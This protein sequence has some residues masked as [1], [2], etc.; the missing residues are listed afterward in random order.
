MK[1]HVSHGENASQLTTLF[2]VP[3]TITLIGCWGNKNIFWKHGKTPKKQITIG[4]KIIKWTK[5]LSISQAITR[6][7]FSRWGGFS[8]ACPSELALTN[9][10]RGRH[11][12]S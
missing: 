7:F 8:S 10:N 11:N 12:R 3:T 6:T 5:K 9:W 1:K 4:K 2:V